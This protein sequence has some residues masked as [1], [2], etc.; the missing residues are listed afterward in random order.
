MCFLSRQ[1]V[2]FREKARK[3][4]GVWEFKEGFLYRIYNRK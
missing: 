2:A 3:I 1:E 4:G